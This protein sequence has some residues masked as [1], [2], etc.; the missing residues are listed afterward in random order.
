SATIIKREVIDH[1]SGLTGKVRCGTATLG[2]KKAATMKFVIKDKDITM[3]FS[4]Y[5]FFHKEYSY[6]ILTGGTRN[7]LNQCKKDLDYFRRNIRFTK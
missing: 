4:C 1:W 3:V 2:N 6:M 5:I 7:K